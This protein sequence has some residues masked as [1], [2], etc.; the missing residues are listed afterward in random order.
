MEMFKH[1]KK[2][3]G[4]AIVLIAGLSTIL[5]WQL[6]DSPATYNRV[7][8]S[9]DS[10]NIPFTEV[11]IQGH[12]YPLK[13]NLGSEFPLCLSKTIL[14]QLKKKDAGKVRVATGSEVRSYRLKE[15]TIGK[16]TFK[17][18]LAVEAM[19]ESEVG[20]IG[21]PLLIKHN[22]L[23]D[24]RKST[25]IM[26]NR[27]KD[28]ERVG[29]GREDWVQV[30]LTLGPGGVVLSIETDLGTTRFSLGTTTGKTLIKSL[31][32]QVEPP[33]LTTRTFRIGNDEFGSPKL[34][35]YPITVDTSSEVDGILGMDFLYRHL[36][37]IDFENQCVYITK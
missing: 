12:S 36:V 30:P 9:L 23:L 5:C 28:I 31:S 8:V 37:Y 35:P 26:C 32:T 21:R 29:Y 25:L 27:F 24:F 6:F 14:E 34:Y 22:L 11:E 16:L 15:V 33:Y 20:V 10:G 2:R 7:F 19:D 18:V 13:L 1:H 17:D 3:I 4:F